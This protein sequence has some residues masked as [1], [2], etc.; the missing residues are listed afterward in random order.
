MIP[1]GAPFSQLS[2]GVKDAMVVFTRLVNCHFMSYVQALLLLLDDELMDPTIVARKASQVF[3]ALALNEAVRN[4]WLD[5]YLSIPR[6]FR[7]QAQVAKTATIVMMRHQAKK[8]C[9][10]GT[11][12]NKEYLLPRTFN[13]ATNCTHSHPIE[14]LLSLQYRSRGSKGGAGP[15]MVR[16]KSSTVE[17][18]QETLG[19]DDRSRSGKV[20]VEV[21]H[22]TLGRDCLRLL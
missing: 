7:S 11:V 16:L 18:R 17:V 9:L 3:F 5:Q 10:N 19:S 20:A 8:K 12:V 6:S 2:R 4:P 1:G 14:E 15:P 22:K 13:R 21:R